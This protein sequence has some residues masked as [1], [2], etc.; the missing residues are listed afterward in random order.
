MPAQFTVFNGLPLVLPLPAQMFLNAGPVPGCTRSV[1]SYTPLPAW[2]W[3]AGQQ[4]Y[5][6]QRKRV[7]AWHDMH[8]CLLIGCCHCEAKGYYAMR[9]THTHTHTHKQITSNRGNQERTTRAVYAP[10]SCL[11]PSPRRSRYTCSDRLTT[12]IDTCHARTWTSIPAQ[13]P[14]QH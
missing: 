2:G 9:H 6:R 1:S 14:P 5:E 4:T 13:N 8:S 7:E 12:H 10:R 11:P 3:G